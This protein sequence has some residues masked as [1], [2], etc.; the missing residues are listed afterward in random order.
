MVEGVRNVPARKPPLHTANHRQRGISRPQ[1]H[2]HTLPMIGSVQRRP[3]G[4]LSRSDLEKK[5]PALLLV[6]TLARL[7]LF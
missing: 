4:V 5:V 7:A 6:Q 3:P 2:I 1:L